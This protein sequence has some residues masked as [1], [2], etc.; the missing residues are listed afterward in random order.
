MDTIKRFFSGL[1]WAAWF[2]LGAL[3]L[4]LSSEF[5]PGY[6]LSDGVIVPG[7]GWLFMAF[8]V[9]SLGRWVWEFIQ[10]RKQNKSKW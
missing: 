8:G 9:I 10:E 3:M 5:N 7:L 4:S 1:M 2:F 6:G